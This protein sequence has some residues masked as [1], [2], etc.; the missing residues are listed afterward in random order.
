MSLLSQHFT[1]LLFV[2]LGLFVAMFIALRVDSK[3]RKALKQELFLLRAIVAWFRPSVLPKPGEPDPLAETQMP[4]K[5]V[6][7]PRVSGEKKS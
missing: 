7:D 4:F 3:N 5:A 2:G 6:E 1:L